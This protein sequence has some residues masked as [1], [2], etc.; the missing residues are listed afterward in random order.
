MPS[1]YT[2]NHTIYTNKEGEEIPSVT[3]ILKIINKPAL[4]KWANFLGFKRQNVEAVLDEKA[5]MGTLLHDA[6]DHYWRQEEFIPEYKYQDEPVKIMTFLNNFFKWRKSYDIELISSERKLVCDKFGGT[7]DL[8]CK[9]DGLYTVVDYK[10]SKTFYSSMF[11]QL[12][13]YTYILELEGCKVDQVMIVCINDKLQEK[14]MT[15]LELEPY[16]ETFL[17]LVDFFY[18]YNKISTDSGFG[19]ILK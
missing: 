17:L 14:K 12:A 11:L 1:K 8:Y 18:K 13:A 7:N 19:Y 5:S 2:K 3:T 10:T 4:Q 15:R 9:M 16:I 6:L